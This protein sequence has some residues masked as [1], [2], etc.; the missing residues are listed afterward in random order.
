MMSSFFQKPNYTQH[1]QRVTKEMDHALKATKQICPFLAHGHILF[2]WFQACIHWAEDSDQNFF[3]LELSCST[4]ALSPT[5]NAKAG[6]LSRETCCLSMSSSVEAG[7]RQKGGF[8]ICLFQRRRDM[9][10][11]HFFRSI[12]GKFNKSCLFSV[13][14]RYFLLEDND[15]LYFRYLS[16][17]FEKSTFELKTQVTY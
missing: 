3:A 1:V 16:R 15:L 11:F 14:Q 12:W 6:L 5:P 13:F 7:Y 9:H 10:V 8:R 17:K 2:M 4:V